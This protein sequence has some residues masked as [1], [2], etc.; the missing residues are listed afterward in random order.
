[1]FICLSKRGLN[2][3]Y[4]FE[5]NVVHKE[6]G[7]GDTLHWI[8]LLPSPDPSAMIGCQVA[9]LYNHH[10]IIKCSLL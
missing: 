2:S 6:D 8:M 10:H 7:G 4:F 3:E 9:T 1:M 5:K